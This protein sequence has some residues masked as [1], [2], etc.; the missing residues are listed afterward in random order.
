M[1]TVNLKIFDDVISGTVA[2]WVTRSEFDQ[3]LGP[4]NTFAIQAVTTGVTGIEP[5]LT[6]LTEHSY[7]GE[8]W[9]WSGNDDL[10]NGTLIAEDASYLNFSNSCAVP[11]LGA[12][13]RF[14]MSLGGTNPKCRLK[15]Y[16]TG[17]HSPF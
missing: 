7:D 2:T 8:N 11:V 6:I 1:R 3:A 4:A 16:M 10:I 17:R 14:R 12:F 13:V 9:V 15:L 5:T